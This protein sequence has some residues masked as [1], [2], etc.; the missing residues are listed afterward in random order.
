MVLP[1]HISAS[2]AGT[3]QLLNQTR[4]DLAGNPKPSNNLGA[5]PIRLLHYETRGYMSASSTATEPKYLPPDR[6]PDD[7]TY[8]DLALIGKHTLAYAGELHVLTH[9][10]LVM[11]SHPGWR[12]TNQSRNYVVT[13]IAS[14][15]GGRDVLRLW[16]R[17]ATANL[18]A[19]I[20]WMTADPIE[21]I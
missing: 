19:N 13:T 1:K 5:H 20:Y 15:T 10:P 7:P 9:G 12:G 11:A 6:R 16:L 21:G 2:L 8:D 14:A 3:W 18:I 17:N 4:T